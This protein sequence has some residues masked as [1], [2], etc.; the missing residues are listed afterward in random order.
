MAL[1]SAG[2]PMFFMGEEVG[3]S[4]PY[5]YDDFSANREDIVG[6][7]TGSGAAI[8]SF[9][10]D[11]VAL[12]ADHPALRSRNVEVGYRHDANRVLAFHRWDAN[13]EFLVAGSLSNQPFAS[14]YWL[15]TDRIGEGA[16]R[17]VFNSD[18]AAYGGWNVG[19]GGATILAAN[20]AIN[21]VLPASGI[22][23]LQKA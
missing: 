3:A 7:T 10:R 12:G 6:M 4:R 15:S 18:A 2:T 14:G 17:E 9:Y 20:G 19:N 5:R 11:L 8:F 23:V 1:L 21:V 16:W 22:I 13:A